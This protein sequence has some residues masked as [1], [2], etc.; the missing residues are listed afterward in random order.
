MRT[1]DIDDNRI[2]SV[3]YWSEEWYWPGEYFNQDD[4]S[5]KDFE[6]IMEK[7]EQQ[8]MVLNYLLARRDSSCA[9]RGKQSEAG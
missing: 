5:R 8:I 6:I 9:L 3:A 4:Q 2:D 7:P 1:S